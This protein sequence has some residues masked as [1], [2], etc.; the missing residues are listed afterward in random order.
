MKD[1]YLV[2]GYNVINYWQEFKDIREK[3]LEYA[4]DLLAHKLYEFM[5]FHDCEG[6]L[7]F[8][9]MEVPGP[10]EAEWVGPLK[11]VYTAEHETADSWIER[12]A[13]QTI[14][15]GGCRLFVVT[16]DKAEQ[17]MV[18]GS[19]GLRIS[20]REYQEMYRKTKKQIAD[21]V[22]RLPGSLNRR[23]L[24]GRIDDGVARH[25]EALRRR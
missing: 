6:T 14:S 9:A 10:E 8:D 20:D 21:G 11:V 24:G 22:A 16:S 3:D 23:E 18:L 1:I 25:L 4:R 19:G 15:R 7:V 17:D 12:T 13:Y 5:A 2:D